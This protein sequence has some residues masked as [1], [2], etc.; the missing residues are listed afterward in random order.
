MANIIEVIF[1]GTDNVSGVIDTINTKLGGIGSQLGASLQSFSDA[2]EQME[3]PEIL[4]TLERI[5]TKLW[6]AVEVLYKMGEAG[7]NV[8]DIE[9][10]FAGLAERIGG[11]ADVMEKLKTVAA[12]TID[13][14]DLMAVMLRSLSGATDESSAALFAAQPALLGIARALYKINPTL[15]DAVEIYGRLNEGVRLHRERSTEGMGLMVD[16]AAASE[17]LA[18]SFGK[19]KKDLNDAE[20][21]Q[22]MLNAVL[23]SGVVLINNMDDDL[24]TLK[25]S[26]LV[27]SATA[28]EAKE[29]FQK[30]VSVPVSAGV[31]NLADALL[32]ASSG[33][34][35]LTSGNWELI[36][37][38]TNLLA[39]AELYTSTGGK[40]GTQWLEDAIA[41]YQAARA[42]AGLGDVLVDATDKVAP[43]L[44]VSAGLLAQQG[45]AR[46]AGES[47]GSAVASGFE[48][49]FT[50]GMTS[51][52]VVDAITAKVLANINAAL[53]L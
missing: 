17:A 6:Q 7:A 30:A 20:L 47:L 51:A 4:S 35:A 21:S 52:G 22:A 36:K 26:Y 53:G 38:Y 33:V 43:V 48:S 15:G 50:T 44:D 5:G 8:L 3:T 31:K 49:G 23:A 34:E 1:K 41:A 24:T 13:E 45:G 9:N 18:D 12:G 40:M 28:Q 42:A 32:G 11:S 46:S 2:L 14:T 19:E 27:V 37:S 10:A 29:T 39:A 16:Y 25:D